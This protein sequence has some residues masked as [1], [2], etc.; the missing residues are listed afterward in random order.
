MNE[1]PNSIEVTKQQIDLSDFTDVEKEY[2]INFRD[3]LIDVY[4]SAQKDRVV[5][6]LSGISGTG[7]SVAAA[8]VAELMKGLELKFVFY[9][10][11]LDAF[12]YSNSYLEELEL[13]PVKGRY[14]TCD[15]EKL[16]RKLE[17][18]NM[19]EVVT[20]PTYSREIHD[21]VGEEIDI[22][23]GK[24]MLLIEGLWFLRDDEAWSKLRAQFYINIEIDGRS[25]DTKTNVLKRHVRGGRSPEEAE[26]FYE[27]SD[28]LNTAEILKKSV[29]GDVVLPYYRF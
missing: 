2:F 18:F 5:V 17:A 20:F 1:F 7:K 26:R 23:E 22:K 24:A 14:D 16:Q 21:P 13:R 27:A 11:G 9:S 19:G 15:L 25:A 8:I 10:V 12:H 4:N 6:S 3:S 29:E 28:S